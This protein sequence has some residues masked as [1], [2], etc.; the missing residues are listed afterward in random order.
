MSCNQYV[1]RNNILYS[2]NITKKSLSLYFC[3]FQRSVEEVAG[4]VTVSGAWK[5]WKP[6]KL[7]NCSYK[8]KSSCVTGAGVGASA[9]KGGGRDGVGV[10]TW[11]FAV[12]EI[13]V[14]SVMYWGN[15]IL[16]RKENKK[17]NTK[18]M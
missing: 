9:K 15:L 13:S 6:L 10:T 16:Q 1:I 11:P 4:V 12:S 7:N 8:S 3:A 18:V 14:G 5:S 2:K 17:P